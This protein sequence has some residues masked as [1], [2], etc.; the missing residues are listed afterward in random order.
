MGGFHLANRVLEESNS[1]K[2]KG[3]ID[4]FDVYGMLSM[5]QRFPVERDHNLYFPRYDRT[6]IHQSIAGSIAVTP[7]CR[8]L[9][10]EGLWLLASDPGW[11]E[12][13]QLFHRTFHVYLNEDTRLERLR[14]RHLATD[15]A[16]SPELIEEHL[17][18]D[19]A[20]DPGILD[21]MGSADYMIVLDD[22]GSSKTPLTFD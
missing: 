18:F 10:V 5:L 3:D 14:A 6:I 17:A 4:T 22:D 19:A 1:L 7:D 2:R 8:L 20:R 15:N 13:R 16:Q 9:L 12:M 11:R 21:S